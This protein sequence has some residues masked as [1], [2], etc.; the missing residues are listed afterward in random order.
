M[1][2]NTTAA[3]RLYLKSSTNVKLNTDAAVNRILYEG[4]TSFASLRDFDADS[5]KTLSRNCRETIPAVQADA[6]AGIANDE[7]EVPGTVISTQSIVRLTVVCNAVKYYIAVG[8][9]PTPAIMHYNNVLTTFKVEHEAYLKLQKEDAPT[10]PNV[11][12]TDNERKVIKW[13]PIFIDCMSRTYG[14]KGPLAYVLRETIQVEDEGEDPLLDNNY[15]GKSGG[16][17]AELIARLAHGD[18]LY[19]SDNKTVYL[20]LEGACRSTSVEST[21]KAFSRT[22]DGRGAFLALIDHHAGDSKYRAISRKRMNLLTNVKWNGHNYSLEKHVSN[23]RQAIEDL[24]DC[25]SHITVNVPDQE[26]RVEYLLDSIT[27]A[28]STLQ[29]SIGLVRSNVN[30]MRENF[31]SA[32]NTLIEVDPFRRSLRQ[33][34]KPPAT[35]SSIDFSSGRGDSGVDLRWHTPQE[36]RNLTQ[37]Q[38]SELVKW[39][40]SPDGKSTLQKSKE[41]QANKRKQGG[42]P[43]KDEKVPD[44]TVNKKRKQWLKSFV[45]KP[46]G[47]KHVMSVLAKEETSN[48]AFVSTIT[49]LQSAQTTTSPTND[50]SNAPA[51]VGALSSQFPVSATKVQLNSIL[52][53]NNNKKK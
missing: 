24:N 23:H 31:E 9:V 35:V 45:K 10:V 53:H 7:A 26:Q 27:C 15:F 48:A 22:Q 32:A 46:S 16:L 37:D 51:S 5:I 34:T 29:A 8:R 17:Q 19:R 2:P 4:V 43:T 42:S 18:A 41:A 40:K 11:K 36:F 50:S 49:A 39:Q 47:L 52:R 38:K 6:A 12:D 14:I 20:K 3:F 21:V 44:A 33:P 13:A 1:P 25:S 30:N 28:D